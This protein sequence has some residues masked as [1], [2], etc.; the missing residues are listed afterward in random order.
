MFRDS[1][2]VG[3][4]PTLFAG[5]ILSVFYRDQEPQL[6]ALQVECRCQRKC[7]AQGTM[8]IPW[9]PHPLTAKAHLPPQHHCINQGTMQ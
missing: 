9:A 4:G 1:I 3:E 5:K 8:N 2:I 6:S 7:R